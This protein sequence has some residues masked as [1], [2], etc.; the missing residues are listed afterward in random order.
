MFFTYTQNN[1]G[2]RFRYDNARGITHYVIIEAPDADTANNIA[3]KIG[4]YFDGCKRGIDCECCGD[5]WYEQY[6]KGDEVPSMY[7]E[8]VE[9]FISRHSTKWNNFTN[10]NGHVVIHRANGRV[11]WLS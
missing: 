9:D 2:G 8:P 10:A 11:N 7:G 1:S 6:G 4:L 3:R 5:R